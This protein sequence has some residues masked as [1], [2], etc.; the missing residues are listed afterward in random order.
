MDGATDLTRHSFK[1]IRDWLLDAIAT[2]LEAPPAA[3]ASD[4][5]FADLGLGSRQAIMITGDLEEFLGREELDPSLLW[6][7][8]TIDKLARHLA[9]A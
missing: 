3:V 5:E 1:A 8:P 4:V 2:E 6:D 7:Y 9:G